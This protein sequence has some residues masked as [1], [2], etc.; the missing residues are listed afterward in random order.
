[1]YLPGLLNSVDGSHFTEMIRL[2]LFINIGLYSETGAGV[3][4]LLAHEPAITVM[5]SKIHNP[6]ISMSFSRGLIRLYQGKIKKNF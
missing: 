6:F 2:C 4:V 3:E 5:Q 1:M